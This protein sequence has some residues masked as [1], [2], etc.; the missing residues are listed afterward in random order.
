MKDLLEKI[1][2]DYY[3]VLRVLF[4]TQIIVNE[5]KFS[6]ITQSEI[7]EKL[8]LST[9]T[10]NTIMKKLKKDN[11]IYNLNNRRGRYCLSDKAVKLIQTIEQL[12][13]NIKINKK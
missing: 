2:T 11:L 8:G 1:T 5:N 4:N 10:I 6:P 7:A 13:T 3:K 9:M 12:S